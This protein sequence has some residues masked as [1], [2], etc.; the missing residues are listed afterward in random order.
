MVSIVAG[1]SESI[2]ICD[3]ASLGFEPRSLDSESRVPPRS[4]MIHAP[5]FRKGL[6]AGQ[7][8]D[9]R[10]EN[11]KPENNGA[12]KVRFLHGFPTTCSV[13]TPA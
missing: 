4:H 11:Q 13:E 9:N 5:T 8:E 3:E 2:N 10:S 7:S 6:P 12:L 1:S